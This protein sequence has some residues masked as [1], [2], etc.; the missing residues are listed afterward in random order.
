MGRFHLID[1]QRWTFARLIK[2]AIEKGLACGALQIRPKKLYLCAHFSRADLTTLSDFQSVA[3][4][5]DCCRNTLTTLMHPVKVRFS[6]DEPEDEATSVYVRDSFLLAPDGKQS[7]EAIGELIGYRKID[8]GSH[9]K[10]RMDIL[11]VDDPELFR[12]YAMM[13]PKISLHY[14][15][16]I[17][18]LAMELWDQETPPTTIG[19]CATKFA[20]HS[21]EA[22][23]INSHAVLGT[24]V[25]ITRGF[26]RKHTEVRKVE[27]REL[28]EQHGRNAFAGGRNEAFYLGPRH[29][30][31]ITIT[32]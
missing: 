11:L 5:L 25:V 9:T 20:L 26:R 12:R 14:V 19:G 16:K 27:K 24:E 28:Y 4:Q 2:H 7:L 13:D 30:L 10:D 6:D 17:A 31:V 21:W 32:I 1:D 22:D 29:G 15:K 8:I 23:K 18:A 3:R